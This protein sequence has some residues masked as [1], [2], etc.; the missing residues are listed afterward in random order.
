MWA[1]TVAA[2][3]ALLGA[4][5]G[6]GDPLEDMIRLGC[7]ACHHHPPAVA[8]PPNGKACLR[9]RPRAPTWA[10]RECVEVERECRVMRVAGRCPCWTYRKGGALGA[11]GAFESGGT[12]IG[13]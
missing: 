12:A 4:R 11:E 6:D 3:A 8:S 1:L 2:S 10:Q 7:K 13:I 9:A 5:L